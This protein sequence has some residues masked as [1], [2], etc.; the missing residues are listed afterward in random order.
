ML[1]EMSIMPKSTLLLVSL[2]FEFVAATV[3]ATIIA[4]VVIAVIV[5]V[6]VPRL[7]FLVAPFIVVIAVIVAKRIP[8]V[9]SV[10][11]PTFV[12]TEALDKRSIGELQLPCREAG[13]L[14]LNGVVVDGLFMPVIIGQFHVIGHCIG[15]TV[16]L[17][18]IFFGQRLVDH[19]LQVFAQMR[20]F[21]VTLG[22]F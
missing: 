5:A 19:N 11:F 6:V 14:L 13:E 12:G 7:E 15:E 1:P 21:G 8:P 3:I 16:A 20:E 18:G 22:V 10:A 9:V 2:L 4:A 17:V